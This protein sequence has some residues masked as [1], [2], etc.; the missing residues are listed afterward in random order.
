M[1]LITLAGSQKRRRRREPVLERIREALQI[2]SRYATDKG[3]SA[4][5]MLALLDELKRQLSRQAK[6]WWCPPIVAKCGF[7]QV[8]EGWE[9]Q[10]PRENGRRQ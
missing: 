2:L 10:F 1:P 8:L 9:L 3:V 4:G 7:P 5:D 6:R